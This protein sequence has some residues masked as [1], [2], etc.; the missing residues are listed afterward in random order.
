M[1]TEAKFKLGQTVM[2]R[3]IQQLLVDEDEEIMR[4]HAADLGYLIWRH[5]TGDAGEV[6]DEDKQANIDAIKNGNRILSAFQFQGKKVWIITEAD[7]SATT[8]LLP[9]EY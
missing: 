2:T 6:C 9:E 1:R 5:E 3:G 8:V 7:R 4:R